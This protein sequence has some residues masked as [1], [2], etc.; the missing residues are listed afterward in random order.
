MQVYNTP[1]PGFAWTAVA[2]PEEGY[3]WFALKDPEIL[4]STMLWMENKGE[5]QPPWNGR[6]CCLGVEDICS[7]FAD[8]L[9][10]SVER[11]FLNDEGVKTCHQLKENGTLTVRYIQGVVRIPE[12]FD[13]VKTIVKKNYGVEITSFSEKVIYTKVDSDF[14]L[15]FRKL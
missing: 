5:H 8:G 13:R 1:Q 15:D 7:N 14:I 6:N 3:L 12:E 11:N 9:A 10:A 4:P 2:V